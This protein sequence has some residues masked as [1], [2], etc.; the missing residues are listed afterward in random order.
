QSMSV[1]VTASRH[2]FMQELPPAHASQVPSQSQV[3]IMLQAVPG[4]ALTSVGNP[5]AQAP[6]MHVDGAGIGTSAVFP[7]IL[8]TRLPSQTRPW[9]SPGVCMFESVPAGVGVS[10]H[11]PPLQVFSWHSGGVPHGPHPPLLD[12]L[13]LDPTLLDELPLDE[14]LLD[15][16]LLDG[17][18]LDEL[19]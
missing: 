6:L 3:A 12:E 13:L 18:P 2:P 1:S 7:T 16:L 5:F 11:M 10:A 19:L 15:E 8:A 14:L 9:Q 17:A 4:G